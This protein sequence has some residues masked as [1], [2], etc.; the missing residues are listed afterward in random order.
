MYKLIKEAQK[1]NDNFVI[2]YIQKLNE[3]HFTVKGPLSTYFEGG[4]FHGKLVIKNDFPI[5][6]PEI[7]MLNESVKFNVN[8]ALCLSL[9]S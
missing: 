6:P 7:I 2:K 3:I 1:E 8:G 5:S 4:L 9:G